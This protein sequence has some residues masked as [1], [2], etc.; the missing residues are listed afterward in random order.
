MGEPSTGGRA[1][2]A[3]RSFKAGVG[4][5]AVAA[6][7]AGI[8]ISSSA[9]GGQWSA[10]PDKD[11]LASLESLASSITW[12]NVQS[13]DDFPSQASAVLTT[14]QDALN[15]T[16]GGVV[17][18]GQPVYLVQVSGKFV[19]GGS[20][21]LGVEA[22][23][24]KVLWIVYDPGTGLPLDRGIGNQTVDLAKLGEVFQIQLTPTI[25]SP[26]PQPAT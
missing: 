2:K 1:V 4:I 17:D 10:V 5:A 18:T 14:R 7:C 11:Q 3:K 24:G 23:T 12:S 22:P 13:S 9:S 26:T 21:P 6:V 8:L 15:L 19:S 16:D 20:T 25:A